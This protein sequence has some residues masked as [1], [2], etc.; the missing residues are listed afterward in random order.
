MSADGE[1]SLSDKVHSALA[2]QVFAHDKGALIKYVAVFE[3]ID[4]DG[5]RSL[6]SMCSPEMSRWESLGLLE[7]ASEL[8]RA[9]MVV[10]E[11]RG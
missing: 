5:Q 10:T 6:W 2:E 4:T 11:I 7:F 1:R 9:A 8:D 3:V